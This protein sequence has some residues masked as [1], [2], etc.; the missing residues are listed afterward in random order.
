MLSK[1]IDSDQSAF[2]KGERHERKQVTRRARP[3]LP[4][5]STPQQKILAEV[6]AG[7]V[8]QVVAT[9][10]G[11]IKNFEAHTKLT[12]HKLIARSGSGKEFEFEI[13]R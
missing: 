13:R 10:P 1:R 12:G 4:A 8:L 11:P 6:Q 2:G 3:Q 5:S 7:Q 9:E